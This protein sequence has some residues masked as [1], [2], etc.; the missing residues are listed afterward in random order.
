M[1]DKSKIKLIRQDQLGEVV[2]DNLRDNSYF[3]CDELDKTNTELDKTNE[4]IA[5]IISRSDVVDVVEDKAALDT[6]DKSTITA[7]DVI[8]VLKDESQDNAET[9]YRL[10]NDNWEFVGS[11]GVKYTKQETDEL[12]AKAVE[13]ISD[14]EYSAEPADHSGMARANLPKGNGILGST[15]LSA[16]NTIYVIQ[17]DFDLNGQ[18]LNVGNNCVL[19]FEGGSINDSKGIGKIIGDNT[20]IS[21]RFEQIFSANIT[22]GGTWKIKETYA[23]WFGAKGDKK[24][25]DSIAI[26]KAVELAKTGVNYIRLLNRNYYCGNTINICNNLRLTGTCAGTYLGYDHT[27]IFTDKKIN[28]ITLT[29]LKNGNGANY[30]GSIIIEN[31]EMYGGN[32]GSGIHY[33]SDNP[34]EAVFGMCAINLNNIYVHD[35]EYGMSAKFDKTEGSLNNVF[36]N[37][38]FNNNKIGLYFVDAAYANGFSFYDCSFNSNEW[39]GVLFQNCPSQKHSYIACN[40]EGNG[41]T[42]KWAYSDVFGVFGVQYAGVEPQSLMFQACY[43][44]ENYNKEFKGL[45]ETADIIASNFDD[46]N[47]LHSLFSKMCLVKKNP[48]NSCDI[49]FNKCTIYDFIEPKLHKQPVLDLRQIHEGNCKF[50]DNNFTYSTV[51]SYTT[52]KEIISVNR[53]ENISFEGQ[54]FPNKPLWTAS[55]QGDQQISLFKRG[56]VEHYIPIYVDNIAGDDNNLGILEDKPKKTI[57]EALYTASSLNRDCKVVLKDTGTPYDY[58]QRIRRICCPHQIVVTTD[59]GKKVEISNLSSNTG[60]YYISVYGSSSLTFENIKFNFVSKADNTFQS[61][62]RI[63]SMNN[64]LNFYNCEF[65]FFSAFN[66]IYLY[67]ECACGVDVNLLECT[68]VGENTLYKKYNVNRDNTIINVTVTKNG[69]GKWKYDKP[70]FINVNTNEARVVKDVSDG[71]ESFYSLPRWWDESKG[72]FIN[73]DG[74]PA[75][76]SRGG[77]S[78]SKP[79]AAGLPEGFSYFDTTSGKPLYAHKGAWVDSNG[80][81]IV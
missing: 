37:S 63:G 73:G 33:A 46:R 10:V 13:P 58:C 39:G 14:K 36:T 38:K 18:T 64:N 74:F 31:L 24:T 32:V 51:G 22:L 6:Y 47:S 67:N 42:K 40:I 62:F 5:T 77:A 29:P 44:E 61:P 75:G 2:A 54:L 81:P 7:N 71:T 80:N 17:Y 28:L 34:Q 27:R 8:K 1:I 48:S 49:N 76:I 68:F 52:R 20:E 50:T 45:E 72:I 53:W 78:N 30:C 57:T 15:A 56:S 16:D 69:I 66:L 43:F 60:V 12:I 79:D 19:K 59:N 26:N 11:L 21:A 3:L 9:Y 23:E 41:K 70:L 55:I 35:F 4:T 65:N 25:D